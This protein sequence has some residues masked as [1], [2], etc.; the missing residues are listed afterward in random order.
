MLR[1]MVDLKTKDGEKRVLVG[2]PKENQ[3]LAIANYFGSLL[4]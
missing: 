3:A 1:F 4:K 2:F